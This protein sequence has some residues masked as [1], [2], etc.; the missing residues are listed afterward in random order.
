MGSAIAR[1]LSWSVVKVAENEIHEDDNRDDVKMS[2]MFLM[3]M[4]VIYSKK[5]WNLYILLNLLR[6]AAY[7]L[8]SI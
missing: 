3:M 5:M 2:V 7:I 1:S 8:Y 6:S 4:M